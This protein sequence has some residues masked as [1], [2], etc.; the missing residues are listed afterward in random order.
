MSDKPSAPSSRHFGKA[1]VV[2]WLIFMWMAMTDCEGDPL[3]AVTMPL[4]S[5]V[6]SGIAVGIVALLGRI[7]RVPA[8]GNV[9]VQPLPLIM[10]A[11]GLFILWLGIYLGL[12]ETYTYIRPDDLDEDGHLIEYVNRTAD[13]LKI[14]RT[15]LHWAAGLPAYFGCLFAIAYWPAHRGRESA[16][17]PG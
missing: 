13:E 15:Q 12:T 10:V 5:A 7:L 4:G 8:I 3:T 6:Y 16:L 17:S 1:F 14:V 2:S 11:A 9:W